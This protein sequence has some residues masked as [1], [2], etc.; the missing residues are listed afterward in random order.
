MTVILSTVTDITSTN[1]VMGCVM[2]LSIDQRDELNQEIQTRM[3]ERQ[4]LILVSLAPQTDGTA[5][6]RCASLPNLKEK[7][8]SGE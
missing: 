2:R 5:H 8:C 7:F 3:A 4:E 6:R 1:N